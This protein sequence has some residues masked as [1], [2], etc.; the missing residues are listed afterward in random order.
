MRLTLAAALFLVPAA[1]S[2]QQVAPGTHV[3]RLTLH[4]GES[5]SFTLAAG[6]DHQL[7]ERA[8]PDAKGAITIRYAVAGDRSTIAAVSRTG[9]PTVFTVLVDPDG[10]GGFTPAGDLRLAGDG[11]AAERSWPG[12]LGTI[13]VGDFVGGPHGAEPHPPAGE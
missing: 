2:A 3:E 4:P 10:D 9:Y 13:N 1:V 8:A 12:D 5:A 6:T 7:L 11:T